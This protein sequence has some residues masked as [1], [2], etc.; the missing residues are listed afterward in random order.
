YIIRK[1]GVA[2]T[3]E[4]IA[5]VVQVL[6][7]TTAGPQLILSAAIQGAGAELAFALTRWK[8]YRLRILVF[9]GMGAAIFSF[10]WNLYSAGNI[11]LAPWLLTSMLVVRLISGAL[12]AGVLGKWMSDQLAKT[13]VLRGYALGKERRKQREKGA[14]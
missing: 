12:L 7:G 6:L 10:V 3:S 1:P 14:I 9:A 8:D 5:G 11:A 2:F 4:L 13:G